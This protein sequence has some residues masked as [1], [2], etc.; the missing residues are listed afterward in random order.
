MLKQPN[1]RRN[2]DMAIRRT[3]GDDSYLRMRTLIA[4]TI[5]GQMLP[6]GVIK[7]G[8]AI[9]MRLGD[10]GTR[11][12]T[13]LDAAT[14]TAIDSYAEKLE[15]ALAKGWNGFA[16]TLVVRRQ[17]HPR[18]VPAAYL[19][20]PFDVKLSYNGQS[21]CT[22]RLE[23]GFNEIGD[24]DQADLELAPDIR[25]A[26]AK[27]GLPEP[28]PISLMASSYQVAQKLHGASAEGSDRARDL[29]D[30][31]LIVAGRSIDYAATR[32]IC[33]RLFAYRKQQAWP[34]KI[35]K[36]AHWNEI[37]AADAQGLAVLQSVDEAIA[38]ANDLIRAIDGSNK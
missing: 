11:F 26:F 17:A 19:M 32:A 7:G 4:N 20:Q 23:V 33:K 36:G 13:D 27:I 24:A 16:G 15:D 37:Y 18:N 10:A 22:V 30:L 14:S 1:S 3:F 2:L 38:W 8:S 34:P 5:V 6:Q 21:W 29:I 12:T 25:E 35:T 31:Q 9:K 28:S